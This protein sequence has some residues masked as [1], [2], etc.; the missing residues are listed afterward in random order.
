MVDGQGLGA[1]LVGGGVHSPCSRRPSHLMM[2]TSAVLLPSVE[3]QGA[4]ADLEHL[5]NQL[6]GHTS[7]LYG[8][9]F[10][11]SPCCTVCL[12]SPG[13]GKSLLSSSLPSPSSLPLTCQWDVSRWK[14]A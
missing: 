7:D 1:T 4:L 2:M 13:P 14:M 11:P 8:N 3:L 10:L 6:G 12:C 9:A 5:I